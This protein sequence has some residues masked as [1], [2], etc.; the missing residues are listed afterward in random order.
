MKRL[1]VSGMASERVQGGAVAVNAYGTTA[2][3]DGITV[4]R[5][6]LEEMVNILPENQI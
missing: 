5:Y 2:P 1:C 3:D 6:T 4:V